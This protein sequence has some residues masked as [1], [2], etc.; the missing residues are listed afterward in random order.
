MNKHTKKPLKKVSNFWKKYKK[1]SSNYGNILLP[2]HCKY[3]E[4]HH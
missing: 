4:Y 2:T 3:K 1:A